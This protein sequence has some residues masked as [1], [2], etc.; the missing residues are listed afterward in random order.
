[1]NYAAWKPIGNTRTIPIPNTHTRVL[2]HIQ[3]LGQG[4]ETP[5]QVMRFIH[6]PIQQACLPL[7]ELE[8]DPRTVTAIKLTLD[9]V[10]EMGVEMA[11][12]HHHRQRKH[13]E[14]TKCPHHIQVSIC[15]V[16]LDTV[17]TW[18]LG[19]TQPST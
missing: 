3:A 1:M 15:Q 2:V 5:G 14:E 19:I 16:L 13:S 17:T 9:M 6:W 12:Q 10:L 11:A 18:A 8:E 7:E 4:Q